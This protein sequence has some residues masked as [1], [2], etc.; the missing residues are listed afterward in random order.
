MKRNNK[1]VLL[2]TLICLLPMLLSWAL[3]DQLPDQVAIHF[4]AA[5]NADNYL[6]KAWAA[7]GLPMLMA[8][9][10]LYTYFRLINDPK[11]ENASSQLRQITKWLVP[12]LSIIIIPVMLFMAMGVSVPISLLGSAVAGVVIV[13]TGNYLPKCRR[14]YTVGIKLPWTLD[15]EENWNKTHRF[16][17]YIWVIGGLVIIVSSFFSAWYV[18]L[19]VIALLVVCP[20]VYSYAFYKNSTHSDLE[21]S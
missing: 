6:P 10:N 14:N 18:L 3:Y 15:S 8:L 13:L 19:A 4:D 1:M 7:F 11:V 17:G 5:G 12:V 2:S 21:T 20:I 16:A 9:I